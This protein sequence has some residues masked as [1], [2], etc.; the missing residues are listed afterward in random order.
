ML[1]IVEPYQAERSVS[2]VTTRFLE[3]SARCGSLTVI[4]G[5]EVVRPQES[6]R[7]GQVLGDL[8]GGVGAKM[9]DRIKMLHELTR[10]D[11]IRDDFLLLQREALPNVKEYRV[12]THGGTLPHFVS[13]WGRHKPLREFIDQ[14]GFDVNYR[15]NAGDTPLI[16]AIRSGH[17]SNIRLLLQIYNADPSLTAN[18]GE[19]ALHWLVSLN[20]AT[21][22]QPL[23]T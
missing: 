8:Y 17:G 16:C 22:C 1:S 10:S 13:A 11:E 20:N 19:T 9:Y 5:Y 18:N 21:E 15:N 4:E 3:V 6:E 12:S 7:L 14:Y 2:S 23:E